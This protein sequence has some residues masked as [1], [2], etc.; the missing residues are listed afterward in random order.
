M[1][2]GQGLR[3]KQLRSYRG[4]G[5]IGAAAVEILSPHD[6]LH[7]LWNQKTEPGLDLLLTP[8]KP[9]LTVN[10]LILPQPC[11]EVA[12]TPTMGCVP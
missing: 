4:G 3:R 11:V 8:L 6:I 5:A 2:G 12:P 9:K 7:V 1:E 10:R